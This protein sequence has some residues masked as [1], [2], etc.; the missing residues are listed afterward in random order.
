MSSPLILALDVQP[1]RALE[2]A[3]NLD[4]KQCKLK[5]GSMLFTSSGPSIVSSLKDLGFDIFLDLK[6]HDIPNTVYAA[7]KEA[8]KLNVWMVNV[9]CSG[10]LEM[11]KSARKSILDNKSKTPPL[12]VGVTMLTSLSE[13]EGKN[14]GVK[15]I[16]K[17]TTLLTKLAKSSG[18]DGVVCSPLEVKEIKNSFG[19]DFITVVPGIRSS[20]LFG[21]QKRIA[22]AS[23]ALKSGSDYLV[24]GTPI[25]ESNNPVESLKSFLKE[26]N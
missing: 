20:S 10:G 15:D 13:D 17:Q 8:C 16:R 12:L 14:I 19:T 23:E 26:I 5:V 2:L 3:K 24:V 21:D 4:P 22:S 6:F 1:D 18:L 9:H 25:T 7:V 11:L